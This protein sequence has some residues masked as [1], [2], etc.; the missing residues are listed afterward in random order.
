[1]FES[2]LQELPMYRDWAF[3]FTDM[4]RLPTKL[5]SAQIDDL[6]DPRQPKS[7]PWG[8]KFR[9]GIDQSFINLEIAAQCDYFIG[10]LG[11]NWDRLINALRKTNGRL[12]RGY[13]SFNTGMW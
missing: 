9:T 4:P 7:A 5:E 11:S 10:T 6:P 12:N 3:Y 2:V 1:M 8:D 13:L